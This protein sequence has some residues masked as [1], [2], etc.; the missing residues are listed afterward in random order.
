MTLT[1]QLINKLREKFSGAGKVPTEKTGWILTWDVLTSSVA[2]K[3]ETGARVFKQKVGEVGP[4]LQDLIIEGGS[5]DD[6]QVPLSTEICR[7]LK[8]CLEEESSANNSKPCSH[9]HMNRLLP[10]AEICS[11]VE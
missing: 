1:L 5:E 9:S 2:V 3:S 10:L 11:W 7:L 6:L 8:T 4:N